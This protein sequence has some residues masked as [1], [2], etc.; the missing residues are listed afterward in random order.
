M[1]EQAFFFPREEQSEIELTQGKCKPQ[2]LDGKDT[3]FPMGA[4][5]EALYL[6]WNQGRR[7]QWREQ[8][9]LQEHTCPSVF[10][11]WFTEWKLQRSASKCKKPRQASVCEIPW[12]KDEMHIHMLMYSCSAASN[13]SLNSKR[14]YWT[15]KACPPNSPAPPTP[16]ETEKAPRDHWW[17]GCWMRMFPGAVWG[18]ESL[19]M[20]PR[21]LHIG[22]H[23]GLAVRWS[24]FTLA[25]FSRRRLQKKKK[26]TDLKLYARMAPLSDNPPSCHGSRQCKKP[27]ESQAREADVQPCLPNPTKIIRDEINISCSQQWAAR[28][29]DQRVQTSFYPLKNTTD[30][31]LKEPANYCKHEISFNPKDAQVTSSLGRLVFL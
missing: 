9:V 7:Q 16:R 3:R 21:A 11:L 27:L 24:E 10:S 8:E 14:N 15:P 5:W 18:G 20:I 25:S 4:T 17:L 29:W 30:A 6:G 31:S 23:S 28:I 22:A 13:G 2:A 26:E 19:L 12:G 1:Q